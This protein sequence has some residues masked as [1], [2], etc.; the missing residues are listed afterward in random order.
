MSSTAHK[1]FVRPLYRRGLAW[2]AGI[3]SAWV[4]VLATLG[5]F[6]TSI[7]AGM[8]FPD[9][10]LSN[11][12]INPEGWLRDINMF[13]EHSHRLSGATMGL[14]TIVLAVWLARREERR[15][16]RL[17]GWAALAIVIIQGV[18]G[19][20]RVTLD[21]WYIDGMEMSIGQ[22]LR[23]PH[24]VLAQI[25]VCILFAIAA[26]LSR[27]WI[28][29]PISDFAASAKLRRLGLLCTSLV[30]VQL[31]I[32]ATMRHYHAGMAIPTF[33]L[34]PEGS[35]LP[36]HWNFRV[37]IHFAHRAM[38]AVLSVALIA[39]GVAVWRAGISELFKKT[40]ATMMALLVM[41]VA[42]GASVIWTVRDPYYTTAHVIVGA[43][44]LAVTFLLTWLCF[45]N[46][47]EEVTA[48]AAPDRPDF[49]P[50]V[51]TPEAHA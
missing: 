2:F 19:G 1:P 42:L 51:R 7:N 34:T 12:S 4:F 10:P 24:G 28:E 32:A 9:W 15:W 49:A 26:A 11:G 36:S 41:Q 21:Q 6:T 17:L 25:Y 18:L 35:L 27:P 23:I 16:L 13:A 43:C 50:R 14:I 47:I 20:T 5:A 37:G 39:Y 22:M 29:G 33:P 48:S 30:T 46:R 45:R 44:T 38:A 40:A 3:G 8:A 31:V